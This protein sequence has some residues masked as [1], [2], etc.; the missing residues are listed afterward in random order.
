M[1]KQGLVDLKQSQ[2]LAS[3]K[4]FILDDAALPT[5]AYIMESTLFDYTLSVRKSECFGFK[6][7][8]KALYRGELQDRIRHGYGVM[9]YEGN[10]RVYEG[11]WVEDKR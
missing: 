9:I 7:Y 3:T 5:D 11:S 8:L 6:R 4:S 2:H 10:E 1:T